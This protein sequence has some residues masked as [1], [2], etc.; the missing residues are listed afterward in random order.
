MDEDPSEWASVRYHCRACRGFLFEGAAVWTHEHGGDLHQCTSVV[1]EEADAEFVEEPPEPLQCTSVFV[2]EPL[3]W[4]V[5]KGKAGR[6]LCP[7]RNG[8][9]CDVKIGAWDWTGLRCSCGTWVCR[10]HSSKL[11]KGGAWAARRRRLRNTR[12]SLEFGSSPRSGYKLR[13]KVSPPKRLDDCIY[14]AIWLRL[15]KQSVAYGSGAY[16][17][18]ES[19]CARGRLFGI[20]LG[21]VVIVKADADVAVV[22]TRPRPK[23]STSA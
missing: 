6:L 8:R 17:S 14:G 20:Y 3:A 4:M 23:R 9:K 15:I 16:G 5:L 1:A 11:L 19:R 18:E 10:F 22:V 7:G 13:F 21:F 12:P 2:E